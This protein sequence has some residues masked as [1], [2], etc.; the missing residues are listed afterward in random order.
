MD[1]AGYRQLR[2]QALRLSRRADEAED[3]LQDTLLAALEA[4]RSEPAWL[5]AVL[6][7]QAALAARTAMRRRK[8]EE[9]AAAG[10]E[11]VQPAT[12]AESAGGANTRTWL[13]QLPAAARQVAVLA[14]HGLSADEIRWILRLPAAAFRQRLTSIRRRL[15]Q[16]PPELR[17]DS[18]ALA[19]VRDPARSA[20]LQFGL[21]R[22]A[23]KAAMRV[24]EGLG[25]HDADGHLILIDARAHT[26]GLRGNR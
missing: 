2:A 16:L 11:T 24:G 21:V 17:A 10:A 18:L 9:L 3:L 23:L 19:Y 25:T 5:A 4:G 8:R 7:R 6:R 20:D 13:Q 26:S 15:G 22:R 12:A 14:L 1:L